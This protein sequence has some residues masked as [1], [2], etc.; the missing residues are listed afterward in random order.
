MTT[1][2]S[3]SQ[4][5]VS[6]PPPP[7]W[8]RNEGFWT[9][10]RIFV[11]TGVA[12]GTAAVVATLAC[13]MFIPGGPLFGV[14]LLIMA[15]FA[16]KVIGAGALATAILLPI[17]FFG[18][19][20]VS[21]AVG[22]ALN[23]LQE[24]QEREKYLLDYTQKQINTKME[25]FKLKNPENY[26]LVLG[27]IKPEKLIDAISEALR[28][29]EELVETDVFLPFIINDISIS[30]PIDNNSSKNIMIQLKFP[31]GESKNIM[32][33]DLFINYNSNSPETI[34]TSL[35]FHS[36]PTKNFSLGKKKDGLS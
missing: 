2:I 31:E 15:A 28:R 33:S 30:T 27:T 11:L 26:N 13:L 24:K 14:G 6:N 23:Y 4:K 22:L 9:R 8:K 18:A 10:K 16:G 12:L 19:P 20:T 35:Y 1:H 32:I 3:Q 21:T 29:R 17:A 34:K 25:E 5:P 36:T 7:T